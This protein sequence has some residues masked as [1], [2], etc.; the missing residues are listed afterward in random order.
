VRDSETGQDFFGARYFGSPLGRFSSPDPENAGADPSDPETWNAYA[1]VSNQPLTLT[2]PDGRAQADD[3]CRGKPKPCWSTAVTAELERVALAAALSVVNIAERNRQGVQTIVD[4]ASRPRNPTCLSASTAAGASAGSAL[5]L[6][7]G[8]G[9]IVTV[10]GGFLV[11]GGLGWG[12]GMISCMSS[13]ASGGGGG[14]GG[15]SD[16]AGSGGTQVTS[17]T[18]WRDGKGGRI[19]VENPNPQQRPGQIHYQDLTGKYLYN[20]ETGQF[21]GAPNRVNQLLDDPKVQAAIQKGLRYLD[22]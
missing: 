21:D 11:G 10:P 9:G 3:P 18:L 13:S 2:D 6:A 16:E 19:D 14:G 22:Q 20:P 12:A 15:G 17:K 8:P 5:G 1:Y 4:W 7:G